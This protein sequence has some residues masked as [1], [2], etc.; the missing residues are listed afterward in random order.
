MTDIG[1][2][3]QNH[4]NY[5]IGNSERLQLTDLEIAL[6][7]LEMTIDFIRDTHNN[8]AG[9]ILK[10]SQGYMT[11]YGYQTGMIVWYVET[12][13]DDYR[14]LVFGRTADQAVDFTQQLFDAKRRLSDAK[15]KEWRRAFKEDQKARVD[16]FARYVHR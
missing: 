4:L 13:T 8:Y 7:R 1:S 11:N 9:P 14:L 3:D 2:W 15:F 16:E 10:T 12:L 5:I 6:Y